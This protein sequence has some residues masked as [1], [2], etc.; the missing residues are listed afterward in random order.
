MPFSAKAED[1]TL[2]LGVGANYYVT[3]N[4]A[5]RIEWEHFDLDPDKASMLS[6][7]LVVKF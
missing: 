2:S 4:V 7:G 3:R 5:V 6:A 1:V